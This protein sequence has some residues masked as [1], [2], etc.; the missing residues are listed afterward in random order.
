M[1]KSRFSNRKA[2]IFASLFVLALCLVP[3]TALASNFSGASV[4]ESSL[5]W[6]SG[7]ANLISAFS[8]QTALYVS[9]V[10]LFFAGGLLIFG[11]DLGNFGRMVMMVVLVGSTLTGLN[12]LI[13]QFLTAGALL[14]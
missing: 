4:N 6:N 11:G 14:F 3:M 10:G 5:P 8:G 13:N 2:A 1:M 9:M 7:M 12:A